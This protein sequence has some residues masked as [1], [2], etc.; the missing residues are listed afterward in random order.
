MDTQT[1]CWTEEATPSL[2]VHVAPPGRAVAS[3][4][5]GSGTL[6]LPA[7]A[8]PHHSPI[9][10]GRGPVAGQ[11][12]HGHHLRVVDPAR[13][14]TVTA[15]QTMHGGSSATGTDGL[16]L[17]GH[18]QPLPSIALKGGLTP[19]GHAPTAT[20]TGGAPLL[21][22]V[23]GTPPP[24][25]PYAA[26]GSGIPSPGHTSVGVVRVG[27]EDRQ[28]GPNGGAAPLAASVSIMVPT[29]SPEDFLMVGLPGMHRARLR[30]TY[31]PASRSKI[32]LGLP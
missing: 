16:G 29:V 2:P 12:K 27:S 21:A 24:S 15:G 18:P 28:G 13:A 22:G 6:P 31:V 8:V 14:V 26:P 5:T 10:G 17:A 32:C 30:P 11:V 4:G 19:A 1:V 23:G 7:L 3:P 9:A 25:A 20:A